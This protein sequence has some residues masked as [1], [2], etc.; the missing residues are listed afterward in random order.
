MIIL[1]LHNQVIFVAIDFEINIKGE[2][3]Y[4]ITLFLFNQE[5]K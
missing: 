3:D 5:T 4:M 1:P 2:E